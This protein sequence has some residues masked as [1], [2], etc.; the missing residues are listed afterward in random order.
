MMAFYFALFNVSNAN[1]EL[2]QAEKGH[3]GHG[4]AKEC[5]GGRGKSGK[6]RR[7][8]LASTQDVGD[9]RLL[10]K[11]TVVGS[12]SQNFKQ[13]ASSKSTT[14]VAAA[15]AALDIVAGETDSDGG[16]NSKKVT[17]DAADAIGSLA[18][19]VE[20]QNR[21]KLSESSFLGGPA[22]LTQS[23]Y[24]SRTV[25]S[26]RRAAEWIYS[27][28]LSASRDSMANGGR[29]PLSPPPTAIASPQTATLPPEA[30]S[31]T[32]M[33]NPVRRPKTA[34]P[35]GGPYT[36]PRILCDRCREAEDRC[37]GACGTCSTGESSNSN[38]SGRPSMRRRTSPRVLALPPAHSNLLRRR[39]TSD[40]SASLTTVFRRSAGGQRRLSPSVQR[41]RC[42]LVDAGEG[43][44]PLLVDLHA[45][46]SVTASRVQ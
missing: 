46:N 45:D 24:D 33:P 28:P 27:I 39:S 43:M 31:T 42:S 1:Q 44:I 25:S 9:Y 23:A 37:G 6:L 2:R 26:S 35:S 21:R 40:R 13:E 38:A 16:R 17:F 10:P 36:A 11:P 29:S 34:S 32:M 5:V 14:E 19:A 15:M 3:H 12:N 8:S 41:F 30:G 20:G 18:V 22:A 4:H 7:H